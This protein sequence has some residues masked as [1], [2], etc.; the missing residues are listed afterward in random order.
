MKVCIVVPCFNEENRLQ[1][2]AFN[3]F[4][5]A[6]NFHFLFVNDGSTDTTLS[7]VEGIANLCPDKVE[8]LNLRENIGKAE[9]VR[10][11]MNK[12]AQN[13]SFD[14]IGFFDSDLATPLVELQNMQLWLQEHPT[15][16]MIMGI[17]IK[18][19]GS[20][21]ERKLSRHYLGRLFAT[22][23]SLLLG[24]PTYDTQC[25]A[26]I[27]SNKLVQEIC[28]NPFVSKWFFDVELLMRIKNLKGEDYAKKHIYEYPLFEWMEVAGS[29]I[30]PKHYFLAPFELLKIKLKN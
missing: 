5:T 21:V 1:V 10:K 8:V 2:E 9:A 20:K 6:N 3:E 11:G 14:Y 24:L 26:K 30:K 12:A 4:I 27:I 15:F 19:L 16:D 23:V 7:I 25:G 22:V 28:E 18:R 29:N 17:R 13:N